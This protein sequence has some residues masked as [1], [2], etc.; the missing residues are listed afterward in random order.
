MDLENILSFDQ[1]ILEKEKWS[2]GVSVE[3]GKMHDLLGLA[4]DEKIIDKY[5]SGKKLAEDLVK[6]TGDKKEAASM[7]AFAANI[8]K[9]NNVLDAAL[10]AIKNIED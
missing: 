8:D 2:K 6:A 9:T 10:K 1:F 3:K 7:L 4:P 5:K